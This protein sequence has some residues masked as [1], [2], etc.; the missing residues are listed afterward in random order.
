MQ[1]KIISH[2]FNKVA[3]KAGW[4]WLYSFLERHP[5]LSLREPEATSL[6]R[7]KGFNKTEVKLFFENLGKVLEENDVIP[8]RIYNMDKT[9]LPTVPA[10]SKVMAQKGQKLLGK[11][12]S[13]ERGTTTTLIA[14]ISASGNYIP[15]MFVYKRKI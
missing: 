10:L 8:S 2:P 1:K 14:C 3:E 15:P 4:D 6:N 13:A 11:A 9:A 5:Q 12:V 7:I